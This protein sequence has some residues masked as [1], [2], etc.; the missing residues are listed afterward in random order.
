M[1]VLNTWDWINEYG[2]AIGA[3]AG[4]VAAVAAVYALISAALDSRARSQPMVTAEF[5]P[6]IHSDSTIDFVLS[7]LGPSPARDVKVT[8][9]PEIVVPDNSRGLTI[10]YL[11]KRYRKPITVLNPG[12]SL[13]NI[14]WA[15]DGPGENATNRE[16]TPPKVTVKVS[17]RGRGWRRLNDSFRLAVEIVTLT[18]Y[19]ESSTSIKGRMKTIDQSLKKIAGSSGKVGTLQSIDKSLQTIAAHATPQS[20]EKS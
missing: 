9:D 10:P 12:Q 19:S 1:I 4:A 14:W 5:R 2:S 20:Q 7:N 18:T 16:K 15:P 13:S 17:Y 6:A 11:V 3:V 8:F